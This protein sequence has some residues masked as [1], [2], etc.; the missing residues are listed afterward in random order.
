MNMM[1]SVITLA[2]LVLSV[3]CWATPFNPQ[4]GDPYLVA[5]VELL[6][7][8]MPVVPD[9][10]WA[11][12]SDTSLML[13]LYVNEEGRV[14]STVYLEGEHLLYDSASEAALQ[15]EFRPPMMSDSTT[16]SVSL[17]TPFVFCPSCP[18]R[19]LRHRGGLWGKVKGDERESD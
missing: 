10:L 14:D 12:I 16:V 4:P 6:G 11:D 18:E 7:V 13:L 17:V 15:W 1:R 9:S 5:P 19:S 3:A 8:A 2:V